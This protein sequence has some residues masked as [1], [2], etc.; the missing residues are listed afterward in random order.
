MIITLLEMMEMDVDVD[1][2]MDMDVD[3]DSMQLLSQMI[4]QSLY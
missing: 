1:R 4:F 2:D 3:V